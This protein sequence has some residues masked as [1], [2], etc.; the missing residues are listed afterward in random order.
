MVG[1]RST[2]FGMLAF[3]GALS[4]TDK[5]DLTAVTFQI[6]TNAVAARPFDFCISN[7]RVVQ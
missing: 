1:H 5:D 6:A 2:I 3:L 7:V 4:C